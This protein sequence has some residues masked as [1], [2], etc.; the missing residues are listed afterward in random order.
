MAWNAFKVSGKTYGYPISIEAVSLVYNKDLV[1]VPP[2]TFDEVLA[3][4]KKLKAQGKSAILWDYTNT[5]FSWPLLAAGG[6]YPFKKKAACNAW[7][8][9]W[10]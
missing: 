9:Q 10:V 4:D 5:F 7:P 8:T 3:L 2:K 1:P 6:G